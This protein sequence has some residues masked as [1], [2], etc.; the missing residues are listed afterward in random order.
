MLRKIVKVL[1]IIFF[2]ISLNYIKIN[3]HIYNVKINNII[4]EKNSI[5]YIT[6]NNI[7]LII[8]RGKEKEILDSNYVYI[9]NNSTKSNIFLAG[10]NSYLVF[11]R[12]YD[13]NKNDKIY[14]NYKG[15]K[16]VYKVS[17]SKYID[18][19]NNDIY[20]NDKISKLTLITCTNNTQKRYIVVCHIISHN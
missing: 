17:Y 16:Y 12:I 15:K 11:N 2:I 19:D 4:K 1:C 5:D 20:K 14:L 18:I 9:M 3:K 10:H 8:K 7:K 13:L 6:I